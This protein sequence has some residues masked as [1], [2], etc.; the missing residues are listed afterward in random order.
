MKSCLLPFVIIIMI[1]NASTIRAQDIPATTEQQLENHASAG[2]E[3]EDDSWLLEM[4][5]F[6]K[7][8]LNI[9]TADA[10]ELRQLRIITDLQINN[11][12]TYRKLLGKLVSVYELQAVPAWDIATIKKLIPFIT[13]SDGE[14]NKEELAKRF[15]K[16][17]HSLL[18]RFAQVLEKAKGF[19][20][21]ITG[22]H[23]LGSPQRFLFRYRYTY[24]N[25]LQWG[26]LGD[27]DAGE[28]FFGKGQRAGFDFYS[29]HFFARKLGIIQSLAIGDFVINMGQG[30]IQWQGLAFRKSAEVLSVKRQSPVLR[31]YSSS[32]E[33]YFNRGI[34]I[35]LKKRKFETTLFASFRNISANIT[36]DTTGGE[37]MATSLLSSGYHRT[38]GEM[39]DKNTL[40][41]SSAGAN[42]AFNSGRFHIGVNGVYYRFS[43]PLQKSNEPYNLYAIQGKSWYNL[44]TDYSYTFKNVHFFGEA[45]MDRNFNRAFL[46]GILISADQR[47][48]ISFLYRHIDA[49]YQSVNGN[50]FTE[51]TYPSNERGLYAGITIRPATGWKLD[52]YGD[53]YR[54]PWLKYLVDAPSSGKD[55]L[56]QATCTPNKQTEIFSRF[57][58]E[59][60]EMNG[61][62][63]G[64]VMNEPGPELRINWRTQVFYKLN[65]SLSFRSRT[66]LIWYNNRSSPVETGFLLFTDLLYKPAMKPYACGLRLQYFETDSYNSRIYAYEN[67]VLY[68]YSIPA[69]FGKGFR[70]YL[71]MNYD[72]GRRSSLWLRIARTEQP[73]NLSIGS[74]LDEIKGGRRTEIKLQLRFLF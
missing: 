33:F 63:S 38:A 25:L 15:V 67:D 13:I 72:I 54:F 55:F 46:N 31:P 41:Q 58:A 71:N 32:G 48:D 44:G 8:P 27:K 51:N 45:A 21:S 19:D 60:K 65:A 16:G 29:F 66:E 26:L 20:K 50:A 6:R 3:T 69:F 10:D 70:Y 18:F 47:V 4:E 61:P 74:G 24:K 53:M 57:K 30:L 59:T 1:C 73:G 11:L 2:E 17:E 43:V 56:F 62:S 49:A 14:I 34:G 42:L 64:F 22:S 40:R 12:L 39:A 28:T 35:T 5:H 68:S 52:F 36:G 23:Y 7:D 9:N 37:E